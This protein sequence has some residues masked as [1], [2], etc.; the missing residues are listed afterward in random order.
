MP[1]CCCSF[2]HDFIEEGTVSGSKEHSDELMAKELE[3][4]NHVNTVWNVKVGCL[5]NVADAHYNQ[6]VSHG[7]PK[8]SCLLENVL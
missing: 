8:F 2:E 3:K 7:F 1:Y 4:P 6:S 5:E